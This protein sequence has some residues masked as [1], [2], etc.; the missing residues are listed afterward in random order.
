MYGL[1]MFWKLE[2][3]LWPFKEPFS[4]VTS[5]VRVLEEQERILGILLSTLHSLIL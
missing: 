5:G 1:G 2:D 4:H 3:G